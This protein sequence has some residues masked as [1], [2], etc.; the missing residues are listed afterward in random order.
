MAATG[1]RVPTVYIESRRVVGLDPR[2]HH[3]ELSKIGDWPT[4][5]EN[6]TS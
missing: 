3:G 6:P 2:S 4:G 5:R 1:D